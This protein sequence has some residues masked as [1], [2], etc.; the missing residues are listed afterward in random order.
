MCVQKIIII[1]LDFS[2]KSLKTRRL[3]VK[4]AAVFLIALEAGIYIY[5]YAFEKN[6]GHFKKKPRHNINIPGN[7]KK[8]KIITFS[9]T[10]E[11]RKRVREMSSLLFVFRGIDG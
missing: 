4:C 7:I 11:F 6:P 5:I 3:F 1:I 10:V 2:R 8:T 9:S